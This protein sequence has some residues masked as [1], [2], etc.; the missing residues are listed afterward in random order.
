MCDVIF[1]CVIHNTGQ[2]TM[3][4]RPLV[5]GLVIAN[6]NVYVYCVDSPPVITEAPLNTTVVAGD[7][8]RLACI[9]TGAPQPSVTWTQGE[10]LY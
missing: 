7:S 4:R 5:C 9:A 6:Y 8:V 2:L 3:L 1:N 10:S